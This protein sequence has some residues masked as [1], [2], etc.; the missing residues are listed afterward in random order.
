MTTP[1]TPQQIASRVLELDEK[2]K[3]GPWEARTAAP[4][5]ARAVIKAESDL[6]EMREENDRLKKEVTKQRDLKERYFWEIGQ[7]ELTIDGAGNIQG[8]GWSCSHRKVLELLTQLRDLRGK[9]DGLLN[10]LAEAKIHL[11]E[12]HESLEMEGICHPDPDDNCPACFGIRV[13]ERF[14]AAY[15]AAQGVEGDATPPSDS[16]R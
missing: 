16:S 13:V 11:Q 1:Q 10:G 14:E 15:R 7:I 3:L 9:A 4:E 6:A 12:A 2:T 5:L 8:T